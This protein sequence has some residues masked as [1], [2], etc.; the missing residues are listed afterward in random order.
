MFGCRLPFAGS[1]FSMTAVPLCP[2]GKGMFEFHII[3]THTVLNFQG[4]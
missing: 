1:L 2:E 3:G 4:I